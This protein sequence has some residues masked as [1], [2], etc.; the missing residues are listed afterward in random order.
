ML[1]ARKSYEAYRS[2]LFRRPDA[3]LD[4][5]TRRMNMARYQQLR[6]VKL[7]R[8]PPE[9]GARVAL[10]W[11]RRMERARERWSQKLAAE[12]RNYAGQ[13]GIIEDELEEQV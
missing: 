9:W 5:A 2:L 11:R 7:G 3:E 13:V 6:E 12:L 8:R 10:R 4:Y 1:T